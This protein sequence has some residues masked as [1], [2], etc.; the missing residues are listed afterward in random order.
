MLL[1]GLAPRTSFP[2][3]I[4]PSL[5]CRLDA[6]DLGKDSGWK[7]QQVAYVRTPE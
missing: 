1:S 5:T 2:V 7:S 4:G 6:E 3:P